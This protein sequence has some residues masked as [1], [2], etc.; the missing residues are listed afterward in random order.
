MVT[1]RNTPY[2]SYSH[3]TRLRNFFFLLFQPGLRL[4]ERVDQPNQPEMLI[5]VEHDLSL[6]T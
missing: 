1:P 2:V 5:L 6:F 3:A 4:F